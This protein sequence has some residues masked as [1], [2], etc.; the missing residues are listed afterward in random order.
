MRLPSLAPQRRLLQWLGA[1][2]SLHL[3]FI[4]GMAWVTETRPVSDLH[5]TSRQDGILL[6]GKNRLGILS[7]RHFAHWTA[8]MNYLQTY[9]IQ[10]P[11]I[12]HAEPLIPHQLKLENLGGDK[13]FKIVWQNAVRKGVFFTPDH[14]S[15]TELAA[16]LQYQSSRIQASAYGMSLALD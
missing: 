2:L 10:I 12:T 8:A 13:G 9:G 1:L 4:A 7:V 15:A 3:L 11:M 6:F 5:L 14:E 16:Y